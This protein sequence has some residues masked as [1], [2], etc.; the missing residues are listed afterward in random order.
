MLEERKGETGA[1]D[2]EQMGVGEQ[3]EPDEAIF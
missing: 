3:D 2:E 1:W